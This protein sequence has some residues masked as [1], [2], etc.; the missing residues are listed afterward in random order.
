MAIPRFSLPKWARPIGLFLMIGIWAVPIG[1]ASPAHASGD[2]LIEGERAYAHK[3]YARAAPSLRRAAENG[4][5][6][7]QTYLGY[8]YQ[9]GRGVPQDYAAAAGWYQ[10]AAEQG[11]P[12]AQFLLGLL[13]DK[14]FGV[15]V[16]WVTA[17]VWLILAASHANEKDRQYWANVRDGIAQK[18]TLDQLREAQRR[19]FTS[20]PVARF[21]APPLSARF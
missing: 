16:D 17:E 19:A 21:G 10:L 2:A 18:L 20:V 1:P 15:P 8:M 14:G 6:V 7:A 13:F 5:P 3:D 11:E 9:M 4:S 12:E